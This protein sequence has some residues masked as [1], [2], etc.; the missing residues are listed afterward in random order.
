M[1]R[2]HRAVSAT[3]EFTAIPTPDDVTEDDV[4]AALDREV[5]PPPG[6][7]RCSGCGKAGAEVKKLL[8]AP[9]LVICDEC[10]RLCADILDAELGEG[11][12]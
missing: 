8:E 1:D 5:A 2:L 7:K 11:W 3:G 4:I 12:R 9:G 6:G 10:V